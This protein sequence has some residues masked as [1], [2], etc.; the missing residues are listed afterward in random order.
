MKAEQL[1]VALRTCCAERIR[2]TLACVHV[3][4]TCT[5]VFMGI[6]VKDDME[7]QV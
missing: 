1:Q 2:A 4:N 6:C 5:V 3:L 7:V